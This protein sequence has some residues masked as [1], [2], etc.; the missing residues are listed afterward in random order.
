LVR[1]GPDQLHITSCRLQNQDIRV[2]RRAL[3]LQQETK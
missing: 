3:L 2:A 1:I